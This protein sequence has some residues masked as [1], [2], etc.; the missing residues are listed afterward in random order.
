MSDHSEEVWNRMGYEVIS[1]EQPAYWH[2]G[3]AIYTPDQVEPVS[4]HSEE[5]WNRM[6]YEVKSGEEPAYWYYGRAIYAYDQVA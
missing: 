3:R 1:G 2:Y 4:D 5:V 6:G